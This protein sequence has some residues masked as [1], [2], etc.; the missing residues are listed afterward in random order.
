M[1]AKNQT[2]KNVSRLEAFPFHSG[3]EPQNQGCRC[4]ST[5]NALR[6]AAYLLAPR[7]LTDRVATV[8]GINVIVNKKVK[9]IGMACPRSP[10]ALSL[11]AR[12]PPASQASAAT[13][14]RMRALSAGTSSARAR[15][16]SY[17]IRCGELLERGYQCWCPQ[18]LAAVG[19]P[20]ITAP[21]ARPLSPSKPAACSLAIYSAHRVACSLPSLY[22]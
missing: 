21:G 22:R 8:V 17:S 15:L 6:I 11:P 14:L 5:M 2:I 7:T 16:R 18:P 9:S 4:N 13:R 1:K 12:R 3:L 19:A 10:T 20:G